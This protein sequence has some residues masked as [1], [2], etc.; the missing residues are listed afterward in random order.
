[1]RRIGGR[2]NTELLG[3]PGGFSADGVQAKRAEDE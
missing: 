1:L 3:N 2:L